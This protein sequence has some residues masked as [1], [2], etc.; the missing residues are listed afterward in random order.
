MTYSEIYDQYL[1]RFESALKLYTDEL[2]VEPPLLKESMVYSLMLGGKRIR[3]VLMLA[4]YD[5]LGGKEDVM[6]F[7]IALEMI[8]TYSLIHDDLPAM[9]NDDFRRGKPSNHKKFGEG[10]AVLAGDALLNTAFELCLAECKKGYEQVEAARYLASCAGVNGM[11]GGQSADLAW[12]GKDVSE[13]QLAFIYEHKTAKLITAPAVMAAILTGGKYM[14]ELEQF[15][16]LLGHL[17]QLTDDILDETGSFADLGKTI[18]KDKE[19]G[20]LTAV[21]VYGL[22]ECRVRADLLTD[23]CHKILEG[24]NRDCTFLYDLVD[25]VRNRNK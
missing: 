9:D 8:H 13:E 16:S 3:P 5:I 19:E 22:A 15:A 10:N 21:R 11:I 4:V 17:F 1:T 14:L 18:G 24:I 6:P 7:A 12:T 23:Q 25:F 2:T 20:K